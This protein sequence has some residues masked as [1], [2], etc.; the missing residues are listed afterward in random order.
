VILVVKNL[1]EVD[2][3]LDIFAFHGVGGVIGLLGNGIFAADYIT[4]LD[5]VNTTVPGPS[6]LPCSL[7]VP[8]LESTLRLK[9]ITRPGGWIQQNWKQLYKQALY[10]VAAMAYTFAMTVVICK[11]FDMVPFL[12]LR[13]DDS[14]EKIGLDDA[15]VFVPLSRSTF[16]SSRIHPPFCRCVHGTDML[17]FPS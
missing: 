2:D 13:A 11:G 16:L 14:S 3:S 4:S 6:F 9:I 5:G 8:L 1:F 15:E 10:I 12:R 7:F 17:L